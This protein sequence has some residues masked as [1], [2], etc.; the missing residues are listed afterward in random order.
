MKQ[1]SGHCGRPIGRKIAT[2]IEAMIEPTI[3][4]KLMSRV[5]GEGPSAFVEI[6]RWNRHY[7]KD[8]KTKNGG[9]PH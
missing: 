5:I 4:E 3:Q 1:T 8:M 7:I 2:K 6:G 9:G